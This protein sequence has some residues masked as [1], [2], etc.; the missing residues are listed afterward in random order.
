MASAPFSTAALAHS[1][2]PPGRAIQGRIGFLKKL[3]TDFAFINST[4]AQQRFVCD[5]RIRDRTSNGQDHKHNVLADCDCDAGRDRAGR[6]GPQQPEF[7]PGN[8]HRIGAPPA[9]GSRLSRL[10]FLCH[11]RPRHSKSERRPQA[12]PAAH[13]LDVAQG[14][15]GR[16]IKVPRSPAR[17]CSITRTA[18]LH[19]ATPWWC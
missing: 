10:R 7:V 2:S 15:H 13:S 11:S 1:Q 8:K 19:Q 12:G 3:L 9:R 14:G 18:T 5:W 6:N 17:P 4:P 16:F